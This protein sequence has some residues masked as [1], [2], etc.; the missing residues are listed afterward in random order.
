LE[1]ATREGHEQVLVPLSVRVGGREVR[2]VCQASMPR[3]HAQ[4]YLAM[5]D[6]LGRDQLVLECAFS[7]ARSNW[8]VRRVR[9][10]KSNANHLKTAWSTL[11]NLAENIGEALLI[12][13][14]D[15]KK[16]T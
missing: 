9:D 1:K 5:A 11:E 14:L 12:Q 15:V 4:G 13:T 3:H 10:K 8:Q 7:S 6:K 16:I 2:D